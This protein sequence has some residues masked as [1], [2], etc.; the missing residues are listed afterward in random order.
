MDNYKTVTFWNSAG[1]E[2]ILVAMLSEINF[3]SFEEKENELIAYIIAEKLNISELDNVL[4][5]MPL[6]ENTTYEIADLENKNWNEEWESNFKA[7][8]IDDLCTIRASFHEKSQ[9][10]YDIE[11]EPKMA[12]GTGHHATTEMMISFMLKLDFKNKKVLDFGCGTGILAILAEMLGAKSI[13]ANDIEEPAFENVAVNTALNNCS[14]ISN[15]LGGIEVVPTETYDII[16]A[17]VNTVALSQNLDLLKE[18]MH[19]NSLI[20]LS[21][22]LIEQVDTILTIC[23]KQG[24]ELVET[25]EKDKWTALLLKA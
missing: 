10:K 12:F 19:N 24:L 16:L 18:K 22:I 13:F 14:K 11:I 25:K 5:S 7:I 17:N 3:D 20:M 21:G 4:E 9:S 15:N 23:K 1:K 6:F 8:T 2:E